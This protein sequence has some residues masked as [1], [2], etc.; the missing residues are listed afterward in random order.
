MY[1]YS[2]ASI[3]GT[4][5]GIPHTWALRFENKDIIYFSKFHRNIQET[6]TVENKR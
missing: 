6:N 4:A 2:Y 1:Y 3:F 5:A